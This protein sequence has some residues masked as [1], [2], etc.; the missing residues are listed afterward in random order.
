[1]LKTL[2]A[3]TMLVAGLTA[4]SCTGD[5]ARELFETAQFEER[6]NNADHTKQLYR[7]IAERYP[8][9]RGSTSHGASQASRSEKPEPSSTTSGITSRA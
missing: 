1:M 4:V 2:C 9:T 7:E 5:N 6:Q 3:A 8:G